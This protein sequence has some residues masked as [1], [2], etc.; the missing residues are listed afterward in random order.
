MKIFAIV[1]LAAIISGCELFSPPSCDTLLDDEKFKT[2]SAYLNLKKYLDISAVQQLDSTE[3]SRTCVV[4]YKVNSYGRKLLV[5]NAGTELMIIMGMDSTITDLYYRYN[6]TFDE[7]K[8]EYDFWFYR[9]D[10]EDIKNF[11]SIMQ[12]LEKYGK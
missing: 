6:I 8:K 10:G 5:N 3:N 11:A 4:R 9:Q 7:A 1:G 12:K 2:T